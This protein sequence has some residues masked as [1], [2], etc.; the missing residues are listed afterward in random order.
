MDAVGKEVE[1]CLKIN[2]RL[3]HVQKR[4]DNNFKDNYS[5]AVF[6][7]RYKL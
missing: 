1:K 5:L 2:P 6:D 4:A 7:I 3:M